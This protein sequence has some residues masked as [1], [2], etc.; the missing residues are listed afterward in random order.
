LGTIGI[1]KT[2][3]LFILITGCSSKNFS[4]TIKH[5]EK[6]NR[7]EIVRCPLPI[8]LS[9]PR[10]K[11]ISHVMIHYISNASNKP[12]SPYELD[13]VFLLFKQYGVSS[14]YLI[15]REG[16]IFQLVPE[17]RVA[18]HAGKGSLSNFPNYTDKLNEFSIG[19]ELLAIGTKE[20]MLSSIDGNT[21]GS[22]E[23]TFI[24]FTPK[25]YESL[26]ILLEDI[27]KKN[28]HIK[29]DR[30]HIIG[31][32]EYAPERKNDPGT[33]FDWSKISVFQPK[34]KI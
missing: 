4:S 20:E 15:D 21:Y 6:Q 11:Q 30:L 23:S 14:H 3:L 5:S 18:F 29:R 12:Y 31:H 22:I 13:D 26:N 27:F 28:L 8:E 24:G 32:S 25:Q 19:I 1:I 7:I 17:E 9:R 2:L 33:L 34:E 16:D 10:T